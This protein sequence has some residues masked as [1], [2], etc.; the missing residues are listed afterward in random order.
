MNA[1]V[2]SILFALPGYRSKMDDWQKWRQRAK[3]AKE[4]R[5]LSGDDLAAAIGGVK[6]AAVGH[7]LT[8]RNEPSLSQF[9]A[10]CQALGANPAT[11]LFGEGKDLPPDAVRVARLWKDAPPEVRGHV[12]GALDHIA[13]L[14]QLAEPSAKSHKP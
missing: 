9:F 14:R 3:A 2:S 1:I 5:G 12:L 8:G 10:L 7:W 11:I 4:L 13:H 6:R